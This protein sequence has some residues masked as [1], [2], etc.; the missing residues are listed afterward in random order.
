ME[1]AG[2]PNGIGQTPDS[3]ADSWK[4]DTD[5]TYRRLIIEIDMSLSA[6]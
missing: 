6:K 1:H 3:I 5:D 4:N 2:F